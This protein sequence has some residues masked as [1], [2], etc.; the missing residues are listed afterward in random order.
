MIGILGGTFDPIHQGHVHIACEALARLRLAQVQFM[1]CALPVHRGR[2]RATA[3][4][5]CDMIELAIGEHPQFV[6]NTLE[7]DRAGPSY[8]IDSLREIR[9]RSGA[10]LVLLLGGDAFNGFDRWRE[11][12]GILQLAHLAVLH[13]PGVEVDPHLYPANRVRAPEALAERP[14]GAILVLEVDAPDCSSSS[15]RAALE[16]GEIPARCLHPAVAEYIE[17]HRL[18]RNILEQV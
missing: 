9:A 10:T 11:P 7:L 14:A 3:S 17:K 13:R 12:D 16:H 15:I 5:R 2:P 1:P 4:Q 18:Y 6:L 8:S